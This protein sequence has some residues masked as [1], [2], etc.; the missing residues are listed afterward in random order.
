[1]K[2]SL[3]PQYKGLL[4]FTGSEIAEISSREENLTTQVGEKKPMTL[5]KRNGQVIGVQYHR[6]ETGVAEY[7]IILKTRK[8][9]MMCRSLG[10][11]LGVPQRRHEPAHIENV[12]YAYDQIDIQ[13]ESPDL[14]AKT[15]AQAER[16]V[17]G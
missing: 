2:P 6:R 8:G 14:D 4:P 7:V 15:I 13:V 11:A 5:I 3:N 9:M 1:M 12:C 10:D 16:F 17:Q